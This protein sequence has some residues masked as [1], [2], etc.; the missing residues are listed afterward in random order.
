M[1]PMLHSS[2]SVADI[3][4]AVQALRIPVRFMKLNN[5]KGRYAFGRLCTVEFGEKV[6][7][8]SLHYAEKVS[9]NTIPVISGPDKA[10]AFVGGMIA[11]YINGP[12][13]VNGNI[14][15][16]DEIRTSIGYQGL[17]GFG[18]GMYYSLKQVGHPMTLKNEDQQFQ[19]CG[20]DYVFMDKHGAIF[21]Q[22][23]H[24][25]KVHEYVKKRKIVDNE[26]SWKLRLGMPLYLALSERKKLNSKL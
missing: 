26:I 10:G 21:V 22:D 12:I 14:R 16:L 5:Y 7:G 15:D 2:E 23:K 11:S 4:D 20:D 18:N 24:I 1:H 13:L 9:M 17:A 6:E 8:K 19:I 25:E 3:C